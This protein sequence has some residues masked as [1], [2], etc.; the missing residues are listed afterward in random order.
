MHFASTDV[1]VRLL[2]PHDLVGL[3]RCMALDADTFPH[4][5]LVVG[6]PARRATLVAWA[7]NPRRV[8]GF[9][10]SSGTSGSVY[11]QGLAVASNARRRG[12]GRALVHAC[13]ARARAQRV[14]WVSLHV[15]VD[16]RPAVSLYDAE[17]FAVRGLVRGFYRPGVY[18]SPDA[19][20]MALSLAL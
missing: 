17:G 15:G 7:G 11:I 8:V 14:A 18:K 19:Y 2:E 10:A 6:Q 16:N 9:L 20:E 1:E 3:A 12:V 4:P 5:S 13:I